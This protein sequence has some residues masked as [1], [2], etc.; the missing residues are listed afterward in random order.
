M[1]R[2][3]NPYPKFLADDVSGIQVLDIRHRIWAEGYQA[4]KKD[5]QKLRGTIGPQA[6]T[7]SASEN[8]N[9]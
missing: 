8:D 3:R 2:N 9:I 1:E 6:D 4:G 5:G 7:N